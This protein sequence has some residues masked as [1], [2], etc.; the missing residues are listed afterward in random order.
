MSSRFRRC[1]ATSKAESSGPVRAVGRGRPDGI[2]AAPDLGLRLR[3]P[4]LTC[5][6]RCYSHWLARTVNETFFDMNIAALYEWF[7]DHYAMW[8]NIGFAFLA[9]LSVLIL[10][11][12]VGK[13]LGTFVRRSKASH[14]IWRTAFLESLDPPVHGVV[15]IAGLTLAVGFLS[16]NNGFSLL[17]QFFP[18]VRDLAAICV[19]LWFLLRAVGKIE[20]GLQAQSASKGQEI[21]PTAADAIGKL[22]RAAIIITASLVA[23]Q[24][25][26]FTISGILAFGGIGGIAI[27]FA[28]QGLVANLF[29]GLTIYASRPFK[30]GE[31]IIMPGTEVMGEVQSIGWRATRVMGFDRR[32]FYVPN[33]L[34]NTAVL[35]NHSRMTSR[36]IQENIHIRYQDIDRVG[37][38]VADTNA[39]LSRHPGLQHDFFVFQMDSYG[40][41]AL[42]LFLYAFTTGTDY[43]EYMAIKEDVL[44]KIAGIVRGHEAELA[45]PTS[46]IH[47]PDGIKVQQ[48]ARESAAAIFG[49]GLVENPQSG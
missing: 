25:L 20:A 14:N 8:S 34:F 42:K 29:G 9:V 17:S 49:K 10:N 39:M 13:V 3:P 27:G 16:R 37:A 7:S 28:A 11:R 43:N 45:V 15:W 32:P 19:V 36:R 18:T 38:I 47:M 4:A 2:A 22:V 12:I 23:M 24:A 6:D 30:V 44:L 48:G 31:W 1:N 5:M 41:F 35:I 40:D 26:G 33:A 46:T 21:D